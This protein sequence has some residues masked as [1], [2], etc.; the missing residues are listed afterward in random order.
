MEK[1][2]Y[3]Q[4]SYSTQRKNACHFESEPKDPIKIDE[5]K[6]NIIITMDT[7]EDYIKETWLSSQ[8]QQKIP[9]KLQ[10]YIINHPQG[11]ACYI[12]GKWSIVQLTC[13][14]NMINIA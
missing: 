6:G 1:K 8:F 4:S 13:Q 10:T 12:T 14:T 11:N 9:L 3:R 7:K 5:E 2:N